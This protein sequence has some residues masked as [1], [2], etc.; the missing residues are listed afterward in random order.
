MQSHPWGYPPC[1]CRAGLGYPCG[2]PVLLPTCCG[3]ESALNCIIADGLNLI[4]GRALPTH[5]KATLPAGGVQVVQGVV[6]G[7]T[8]PSVNDAFAEWVPPL[9]RNTLSTITYSGAYVC[10]GCPT[11]LYSM[12]GP[13]VKRT[14]CCPRARYLG[15]AVGIAIAGAVCNSSAGWPG[16]FYVCVPLPKGFLKGRGKGSVVFLGDG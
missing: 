7:V 2:R 1:V 10:R 13:A 12:A 3:C 16:A 6:Q 9:E 5:P 14:T 11:C 15:A 4:L 8:Y